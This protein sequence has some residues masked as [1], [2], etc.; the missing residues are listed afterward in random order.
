MDLLDANEELL[1]IF[2][3]AMPRASKFEFPCWWARQV[4]DCAREMGQE[5]WS[6]L[7]K[8]E[9]HH[10]LVRYLTLKAGPMLVEVAPRAA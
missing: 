10:A 9:Q 2:H 1:A 5:Q 7:S 4:R 8:R 3:K 6:S